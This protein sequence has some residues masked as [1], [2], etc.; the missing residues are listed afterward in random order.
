MLRMCSSYRKKNPEYFSR[1]VKLILK[2]KLKK[3]KIKIKLN[4]PFYTSRQ[5]DIHPLKLFDTI[6]KLIHFLMA[7]FSSQKTILQLSRLSAAI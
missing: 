2:F 4:L 1:I 3:N 5:S 6:L 7:F